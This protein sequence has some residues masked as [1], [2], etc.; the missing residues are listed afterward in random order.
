MH[1]NSTGDRLISHIGYTLLSCIIF[2]IQV[3]TGH[4]ILS[5]GKYMFKIILLQIKFHEVQVQNNFYKIHLHL[6]LNLEMRELKCKLVK[7]TYVMMSIILHENSGINKYKLIETYVIDK[8]LQ[9]RCVHDMRTNHG[10]TGVYL[11]LSKYLLTYKYWQFTAEFFVLKQVLTT[12]EHQYITWY[13]NF[14]G[15]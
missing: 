7:Q 4:F 9:N 12:P 6:I 1:I 8:C 15:S 5:N 14:V 13:S 2:N 3:T 10:I 11:Q